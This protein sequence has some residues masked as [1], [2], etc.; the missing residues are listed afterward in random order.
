MLSPYGRREW[1][2]IIAVGL[3]LTLSALIL[4]WWIPAVII[5]VLTAALVAFFRDPHR[6]VPAQRNVAVSPADGRISS[7]HHLEYYEPF[8][9][10]AVCIRVFLSVLDVHV[11][12]APLHGMVQSTVH[13]PGQHLNAL[14]PESAQDN[15]SNLIEF[16]HPM[17]QEP[18]ATVRQ[19]AGLIARTI[20]CGVEP[21]EIVQ[22]GQRIGLIK[23]GSTTELYL[24]GE[25]DPEVEVKEKQKVYGGLTVLA[26]ITP[27]E[28][29][30][31][32][33]SPAAVATT[34]SP[35]A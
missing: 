14:N 24:P 7:I 3:L 1:T 16:V 20:H 31:P 12:R 6:P 17:T 22:R 27:P 28:R 21:G 34:Q 4:G 30:A 25:F 10:P 11:N 35:P 2:T 29:E 13:T 32:D 9:G 23:F 18:V 26:R 15:E 19:V 33:E 5:L 8:D